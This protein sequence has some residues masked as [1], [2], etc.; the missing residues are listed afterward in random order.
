[1]VLQHEIKVYTNCKSKRMNSPVKYPIQSRDH[2]VF[3]GVFPRPHKGNSSMRI[4]SS[5]SNIAR[6]GKREKHKTSTCNGIQDMTGNDPWVSFSNGLN[7]H[8]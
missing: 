5:L 6:T 8:K 4:S 2:T 1:M 7:I 3:L